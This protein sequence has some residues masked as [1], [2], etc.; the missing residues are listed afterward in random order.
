MFSSVIYDFIKDELKLVQLYGECQLI[1]GWEYNY[2]FLGSDTTF[3]RA[4]F[5]TISGNITFLT[6]ST[7]VLRGNN[8]D[9]LRQ[10]KVR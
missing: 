9:V 2:C 6:T 3:I 5:A 8:T 1:M 4:P 7:L 10:E